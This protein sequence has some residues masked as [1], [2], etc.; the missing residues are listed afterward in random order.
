MTACPSSRTFIFDL[1]FF[2]Y[3]VV[4]SRL[5]ASGSIQM[6]IMLPIQFVFRCLEFQMHYEVLENISARASYLVEQMKRKK[7]SDVPSVANTDGYPV[8]TSTYCATCPR[9]IRNLF[10]RLNY[11]KNAPKTF[12]NTMKIEGYGDFSHF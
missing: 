10:R 6:K 7:Q 8:K 9:E 4:S 3:K 12:L 1:F 5:D 11:T 2:A